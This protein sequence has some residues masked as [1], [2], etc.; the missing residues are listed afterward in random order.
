MKPWITRGLTIAIIIYALLHFVTAF[1]PLNLLT[2]LLSIT[3]FGLILLACIHFTARRFKLP[4]MLFLIGFLT[5]IFSG[6]TPI[7]GLLHGFLQMR[8]VIGLLV[9]VP[10]IS[11]VLREE[12]YIDAILSFAHNMIDSSRKLYVGMISFT[13]IISYFL[14]FGAIPMM[15]QFISNFLSH[16]RGEEWENFKG[17]ATLRG[18]AFSSLWVISIPSFVYAVETMEASLWISILQGLGISVIGVIIAVLFSQFEEKRYGVNLTTDIRDE[19]SAVLEHDASNGHQKQYVAEFAILFVSLFGSIFLLHALFGMELMLLI[20]LVIIGWTAIYYLVKRK[21]KKFLT[22]AKEYMQEDMAKQSYQLNVMLGAGMLIYGLNQTN[23]AS[24]V[25]DGIYSLQEH[26]PFINFLYVLPFIVIILGFMGLGPLTV[27]VLVAG[28]LQSIDLPYPPELVVLT[29]TSGS[30][31][32][33]LLSPLIMPTIVL[34]GSNGLSP[35]KNGI[36]FNWKFAIVFYLIVQLY[37]QVM[38]W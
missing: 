20:P 30:V 13:Q 19:I 5:F 38:V 29:V 11:W 15:Y 27:M 25:V 10:M 31:I 34:S 16:E 24:Y 9:I 17:T 32:S 14:L 18:F 6:G 4:I 36:K 37:V 21:P 12:P 35:I 1:V 26:I 2:N 28:I 23:F 7:D 22:E 33:I 8:N 3:G